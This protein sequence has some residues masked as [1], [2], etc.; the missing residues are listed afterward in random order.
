MTSPD[1]G[2]TYNVNLTVTAMSGWRRYDQ[3]IIS[4][5]ASCTKTRMPRNIINRIQTIP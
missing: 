3:A 4:S 2:T 5:D 1:D